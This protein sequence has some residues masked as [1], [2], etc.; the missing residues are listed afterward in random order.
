M[1]K[2]A[3]YLKQAKPKKLES[4]MKKLQKKYDVHFA[5]KNF[6]MN[7]YNIQLLADDVT[8]EIYV[9][10]DTYDENQEL[11]PVNFWVSYKKRRIEEKTLTRLMDKLMKLIKKHK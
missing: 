10:E 3:T 5:W 6:Q 8:V 4:E 2:I 9:Q 1:K 11:Y 7:T